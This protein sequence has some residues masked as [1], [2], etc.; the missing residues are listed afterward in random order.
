MLQDCFDHADMDMFRV[1][2]ENNLDLYA[3]S[4]SEFIRKCIGDVVPTATIKTYPYQKPW[5]DGGIRVKLNERTTSFNHGKMTG[6]MVEYKQCSYS[7]CKSIK[8]A[9]C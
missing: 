2:S 3:D 7:L 4:V 1:A 6:N 9:K 8:Q 5:I